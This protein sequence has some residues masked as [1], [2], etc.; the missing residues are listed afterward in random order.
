[1]SWN[2]WNSVVSIYNCK[3][4]LYK[5]QW[6]IFCPVHSIFCLLLIAM[7]MRLDLDHLLLRWLVWYWLQALL[8][9]A[10]SMLMP[11]SN[12]SSMHDAGLV[13]RPCLNAKSEFS[14]S[15]ENHS[16]HSNHLNHSWSVESLINLDHLIHVDLWLAFELFVLGF[17]YYPVFAC[18]RSPIRLVGYI[19]GIVYSIL[20]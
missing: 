12:V 9:Q 6:F 20:L 14:W 17:A 1:M 4:C 7:C 10:V 13:I 3:Y 5:L 8:T 18:I 19:I 2:S 15:L 11:S 16:N